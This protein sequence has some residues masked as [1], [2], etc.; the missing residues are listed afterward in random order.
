MDSAAYVLHGFPPAQRKEL[1][2][3]LDRAADA[4]EALLSSGLAAAQNE[5]NSSP[6][7]QETR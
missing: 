7:S 4:V 6:A 5:F 2:F 3:A 1:P